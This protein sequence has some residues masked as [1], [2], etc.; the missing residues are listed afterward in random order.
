[1]TE[2]DKQ[3]LQKV[4]DEIKELCSKERYDFSQKVDMGYYIEDFLQRHL[5]PPVIIEIPIKK[6]D[7]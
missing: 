7:D 4:V 5:Q 2:R 1:M 3:V 6:E